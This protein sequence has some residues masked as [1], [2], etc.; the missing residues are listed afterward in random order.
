MMLH[1]IQQRLTSA[2]DLLCLDIGLSPK[3]MRTLIGK[4]LRAFEIK[5]KVWL[6]DAS[7]EERHKRHKASKAVDATR[8]RNKRKH[9]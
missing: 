7:L 5:V 2:I 4:E 3:Y 1:F 8:H 9:D 6:E